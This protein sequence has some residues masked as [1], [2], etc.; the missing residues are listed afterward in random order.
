MDLIRNAGA[1]SRSSIMGLLSHPCT[2]FPVAK[3]IYAAK[4]KKEKQII[5]I[6]F[7]AVTF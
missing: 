6:F 4:W 3:L 5:F 1:R 2:V 7:S